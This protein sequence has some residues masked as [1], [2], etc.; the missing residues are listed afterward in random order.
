M[1]VTTYLNE[2]I[3]SILNKVFKSQA[4]VAV[5]HTYVDTYISKMMKEFRWNICKLY[6]IHFRQSKYKVYTV[7]Q[8][9]SLTW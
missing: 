2:Q 9:F 1:Q 3:H 7:T 5:N 6:F 4:K 8:T